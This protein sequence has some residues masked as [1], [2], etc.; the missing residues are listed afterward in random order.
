MRT[1]EY[2]QLVA[3][4]IYIYGGVCYG[5]YLKGK[6]GVVDVTDVCTM[7]AGKP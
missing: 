2:T 5:L 1:P 7:L 4:M 3:G 6:P